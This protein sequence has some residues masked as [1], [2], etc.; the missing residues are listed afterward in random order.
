VGHLLEEIRLHGDQTELRDEVI[1]LARRYGIVTPYTAW[2]IV[3]DEARRGLSLN[4]QSLP[5]LQRD[6][7]ARQVAGD[8]YQTLMMERYGLAPVAR[9]RSD[10]A[11]KQAQAPVSAIQLGQAEAARGLGGV[12]AAPASG[13]VPVG[14]VSSGLAESDSRQTVV[15]TAQQ[16]QYAGG[17]AFYWNNDRWLDTTVQQQSQAQRRQISFGSPEYFEL[18]RRHPESQAW[19]ALGT[20]VEF[21]L[22]STVYEI[23]E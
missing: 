6:T 16:V 14:S 11:L 22:G 3:E 12:P 1:E 7:A 21:V 15:A 18:T 9:S 10:A 2:L 5:T 4:L 13:P 17:R 20:R 8:Q 23:Q 19:L